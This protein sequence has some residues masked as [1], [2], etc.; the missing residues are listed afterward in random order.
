MR[1]KHLAM[2]LSK[3][4]PH[5]CA[6]VTLE[7][8]A[9]EGDLAAYWMLAV[10]ELDRVENRV[11][12]DLGAGNGVLGVACLLLGAA[13]VH[14]YECDEET[15][16][17]L[18]TNLAGLG[19]TFAGRWTVHCV[20]LGQDDVDLSEVDIVVMNPPWGVQKSK[21]DRPFLKA[22]F[23]SKAQS[24]HLLHSAGAAHVEAVGLGH[25]W[26]NEHV[27]RTDFRLPPTYTH[28]AKRKGKTE[29][30]CWRFF[31]PGDARLD[32]VNDE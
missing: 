10:D 21:A 19:E 30:Q 32:T 7:Q 26:D 14:F 17:V 1:P 9:T 13:H 28:H 5:P 23:A 27:L 22:A 8:Y 11:I 18:K 2:A 6:D 24:V 20:V 3:L 15:E 12:A 29:V 16:M 31:R 4:T 25:G